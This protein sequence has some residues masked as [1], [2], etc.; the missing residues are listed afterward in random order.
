MDWEGEEVLYRIGKGVVKQ[1]QQ[2]QEMSVMMMSRKQPTSN[3]QSATA[4]KQ[5]TGI[6][7]SNNE[8]GI[9]RGTRTDNYTT[10]DKQY[11]M[12][13]EVGN[14]TNEQTKERSK[15]KRRETGKPTR[16]RTYV[17]ERTMENEDGMH[18]IDVYSNASQTA[19]GD[20]RTNERKDETRRDRGYVM[21]G[22]SKNGDERRA[23]VG[24]EHLSFNN[25][26]VPPTTTSKCVRVRVR[27]C[28]CECAT[29]PPI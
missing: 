1:Q 14:E 21:R 12:W 2:Q 19:T 5:A 17:D 13:E 25:H 28:V 7:P 15:A 20:E 16:R 6:I 10:R 29:H 8:E 11:E 4:N 9:N 24:P 22:I 26:T 3:K 27:E 23:N 18:C